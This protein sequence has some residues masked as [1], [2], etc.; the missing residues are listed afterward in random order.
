M[1]D[2]MTGVVDEATWIDP[3]D[4]NQM[5][6]TLAQIDAMFQSQQNGAMLNDNAIPEPAS[7]VLVAIAAPVIGLVTMR[8]RRRRV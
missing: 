7:L 3:N 8:R 6:Y 5:P 1:I 4:P 2:A